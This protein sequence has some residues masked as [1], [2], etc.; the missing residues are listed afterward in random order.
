LTG[1]ESLLLD[2]GFL[3]DIPG[4]GNRRLSRSVLVADDR[5]MREGSVG[6]VSGEP[7]FVPDERRDEAPVER[8][9]DESEPV[10]VSGGTEEPGTRLV[11]GCVIPVDE[12]CRWDGEDD[13][14]L[15]SMLVGAVV[16]AEDDR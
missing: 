12:W 9:L 1:G 13:A 5:S 14:G 3:T 15:G 8:P 7:L 11:T 4:K 16:G 10:S 6:K 2:P